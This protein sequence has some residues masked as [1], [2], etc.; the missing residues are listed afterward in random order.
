MFVSS[1]PANAPK[2]KLGDVSYNNN[3]ASKNNKPFEGVELV[4]NPDIFSNSGPKIGQNS[5]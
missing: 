4:F 1:E 2:P 5:F 3:F